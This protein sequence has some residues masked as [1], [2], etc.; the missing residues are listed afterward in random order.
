VHVSS[1]AQHYDQLAASTKPSYDEEL[2]SKRKASS[3]NS[4][5]KSAKVP[6]HV[7]HGGGFVATPWPV[8]ARRSERREK[9]KE[10]KE[11]SEERGGR[12]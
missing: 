8:A 12:G 5:G 6:K 1:F 3:G 10:A 9:R 11:K 2:Q 7:K 4:P